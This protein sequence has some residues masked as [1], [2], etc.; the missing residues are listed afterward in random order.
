M[1]DDVHRPDSWTKLGCNG[2]L[3]VP[4]TFAQQEFSSDMEK[5]VEMGH[6]GSNCEA[7]RLGTF[8]STLACLATALGAELQT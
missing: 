2:L 4:G 8:L 1:S 6:S 7:L 3:E 5:W